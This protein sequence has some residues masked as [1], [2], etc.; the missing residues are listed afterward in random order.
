[1]APPGNQAANEENK[2][3]P[4]AMGGP[5]LLD[6]GS[7]SRPSSLTTI[8]YVNSHLAIVKCSFSSYQLEFSSLELKG[9]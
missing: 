9:E 6:N 3:Q 4:V 7:V 2:L 5:G 8:E 1:V